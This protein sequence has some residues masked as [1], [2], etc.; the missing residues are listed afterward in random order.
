MLYF[1]L[2]LLV[3]SYGICL[4][5]SDLFHL[6]I[7]SRSICVAA[8]GILSLSFMAVNSIGLKSHLLNH[9][10]RYG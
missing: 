4:S 2:H 9:L 8:N 10:I 3:I 1:R 7:I 6:V 5:L